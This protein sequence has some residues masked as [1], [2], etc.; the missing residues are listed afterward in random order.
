[1]R[2]TVTTHLNGID[3]CIGHK[4][5]RYEIVLYR[6]PT[7]V[8]IGGIDLHGDE[9]VWAG[10]LSHILQYFI[11]DACTATLV[12][13]ISV[14]AMI[15]QR[16]D[17]LAQIEEVGGMNLYT[18]VTSLFRP[19]GSIAEEMHNLFHLLRCQLIHR[20]IYD[21]CLHHYQGP[22]LVDGISQSLMSCNEAVV[23]K[24]GSTANLRI[25]P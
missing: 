9:E 17:E 25:I 11:E 22:M 2:R 19:V 24:L 12:T 1:M 18:V 15:Q 3:A 14:G 13:T 20:P 8:F 21:S 4:L 23:I 16:T 7:W 6:Q 10:L 5:A